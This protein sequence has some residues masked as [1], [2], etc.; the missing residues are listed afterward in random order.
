[1]VKCILSLAMKYRNHPNRIV[2]ILD[3]FLWSIIRSYG[4]RI[5]KRIERIDLSCL[6]EKK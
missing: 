1:M 6:K 5:E 4:N 3:K 2:R